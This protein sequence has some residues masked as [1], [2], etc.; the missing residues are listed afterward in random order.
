M[1]MRKIV[2]GL[3]SLAAA[4]ALAGCSIYGEPARPEYVEISKNILGQCMDRV[5]PALDDGRADPVSVAFAVRAKCGAEF[6]AYY[7]MVAQGYGP[8][9]QIEIMRRSPEAEIEAATAA[10]LE[11][12]R[13]LAS[14]Q[15]KPNS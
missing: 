2:V 14:L 10:V 7:Q 8:A 15:A 11:Y 5:I 3:G 9:T 13:Y 12:R 1:E 4:S 6:N